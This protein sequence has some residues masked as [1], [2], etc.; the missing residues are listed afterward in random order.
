MHYFALF[1]I[2]TIYEARKRTRV[3]CPH[4]ITVIF[5]ILQDIPVAG[6]PAKKHFLYAF[7]DDDTSI[8]FMIVPIIIKSTFSMCTR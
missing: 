4:P 3:T 8:D 5:F 7:E 1:L 2:C 6:F